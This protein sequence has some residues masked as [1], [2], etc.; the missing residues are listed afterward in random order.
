MS[1]HRFQS[2]TNHLHVLC[3]WDRPLQGFFLVID[4][5]GTFES[6]PIYSNLYED[7]PHPQNFD[8]FAVVL[9]RF[10]ID[11]PSGLLEALESDKTHNAGNSINIWS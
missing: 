1:Q 9:A 3:G 8:G 6:T 5:D 2:Q 7:N 10:G 11:M 4:R